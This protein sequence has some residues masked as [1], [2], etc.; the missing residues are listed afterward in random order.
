MNRKDYV[1]ILRKFLAVIIIFSMLQGHVGVLGSFTHVAYAAIESSIEEYFDEKSEQVIQDEN[2]QEDD[3]EFELNQ[4]LSTEKSENTVNETVSNQ[5]ETIMEN[6]VPE[7]V[8]EEKTEDPEET[9]PLN[10]RKRKLSIEAESREQFEKDKGRLIE[11]V[12]L[13]IHACQEQLNQYYSF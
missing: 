4:S 2:I 12:E 1:R 7:E 10:V 9:E 13:K 6:V 11:N 3:E 5:E 8:V